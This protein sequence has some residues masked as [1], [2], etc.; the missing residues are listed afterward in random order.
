MQKMQTLPRQGYFAVV[1]NEQTSPHDISKVSICLSRRQSMTKESSKLFNTLNISPQF[2]GLSTF[3]AMNCQSIY[4][5]A[6]PTE[7]IK[8]AGPGRGI[9]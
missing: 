7:I 9:F 5:E 4:M 3:H 1:I 6:P 2:S 8:N